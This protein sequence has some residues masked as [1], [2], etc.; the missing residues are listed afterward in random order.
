MKI[1]L[2]WLRHQAIVI[3]THLGKST[4]TE[5]RGKISEETIDATLVLVPEHVALQHKDVG[6]IKDVNKTKTESE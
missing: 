4:V 1:V 2:D 6:N 3:R 5:R